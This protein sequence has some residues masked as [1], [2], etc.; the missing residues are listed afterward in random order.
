MLLSI[1]GELRVGTSPRPVM[2]TRLIVPEEQL[3]RLV[4]TGNSLGPLAVKASVARTRYTEPRR[5]VTSGVFRFSR[6]ARLEPNLEPRAIM[7]D[8]WRF[9][10]AVVP[11]IE[12]PEKVEAPF[13]LA[14]KRQIF[15]ASPATP[16]D[17]CAFPSKW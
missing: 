12:C 15:T 11:M 7:L 4:G 13:E 17:F 3:A 5:V 8:E 9:I 1:I 14:I 16:Q 2:A 10:E 6:S